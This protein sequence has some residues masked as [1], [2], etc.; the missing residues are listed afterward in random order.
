MSMNFD[1]IDD[2]I[3]TL[4]FLV[5]VEQGNASKN[6]VEGFSDEAYYPWKSPK[7]KSTKIGQSYICQ[8]TK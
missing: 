8:A 1:L 3:A 6:W 2:M 7:K 5:L 4:L